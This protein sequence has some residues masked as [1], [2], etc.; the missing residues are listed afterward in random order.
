MHK[1]RRAIRL[2]KIRYLIAIITGRHRIKWLKKHNIF[3]L[4]GKRTLYQPIRLP[5][6]PQLI[7][8]HDNVRI[9]SNV[10]FYEHDG[11][12]WV[13]AN[14][15]PGNWRMHHTC[16][17]IFDNCFIGGGSILVGNLRIGP[18]A[19]VAAGSVVVKDVPEGSIVGG[20]PAKV[21]G[22]FDD[23]LAKRMEEDYEKPSMNDAD[24]IKEA[25]ERFYAEKGRE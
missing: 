16:I 25:W 7:K 13:L 23:L 9:A 15:K 19:I 11:I 18:N 8:I 6:T 10:T 2:M 21:I 14:V 24:W 17:E 12:N 3:R 1:K 20:N 4:L 22:R 5:N